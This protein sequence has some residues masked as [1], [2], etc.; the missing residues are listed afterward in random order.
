MAR[1]VPIGSVLNGLSL[2]TRPTGS[3]SV[4]RGFFFAHSSFDRDP[5]EDFINL[6]SF[7]MNPPKEKPEKV[8]LLINLGLECTRK[9][10]HIESCFSKRERILKIFSSHVQIQ[11]QNNPSIQN[12]YAILTNVLCGQLWQIPHFCQKLVLCDNYVSH[13]GSFVLVK[14]FGKKTY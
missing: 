1:R 12:Y 11:I 5:T 8:D 13:R 4:W 14:G 3:T 2:K 9:T 6:F 10:S 7:V